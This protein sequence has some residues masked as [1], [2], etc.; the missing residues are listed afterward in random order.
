MNQLREML[1]KFDIKT[2]ECLIY[3]NRIRKKDNKKTRDVKFRVITRDNLKF[4]DEIGWLKQ[5]QS[6]KE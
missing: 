1:S 2:T 6:L 3:G 5:E 4:M